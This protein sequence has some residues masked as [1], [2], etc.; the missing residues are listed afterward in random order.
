[1]AGGIWLA[2]N[3]ER[4]GAYINFQSV[5][6]PMTTLCTRGVVAIPMALPWGPENT[7]ITL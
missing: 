5:P 7:V 4:A 1:M 2:Q 6:R 3:K